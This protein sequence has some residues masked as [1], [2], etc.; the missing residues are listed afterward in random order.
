MNSG[1]PLFSEDDD[2]GFLEHILEP[3]AR[4]SN[5]T[6][7]EDFYD[8]LSGNN[9]E[10]YAKM[11]NIRYWLNHEMSALQHLRE[12][13]VSLTVMADAVEAKSIP[14]AVAKPVQ[15][16]KKISKLL[17]N[18]EYLKIRLEY[19]L[20]MTYYPRFLV[21]PN[22]PQRRVCSMSVMVDKIAEYPTIKELVNKRY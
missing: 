18:E 1:E 2:T 11:A 22:E 20:L 7:E 5:Q 8:E 16:S 17:S 15:G 14:G 21:I 4:K 3:A 10:K 19:Y 6:P 12:K 9:G 13:G